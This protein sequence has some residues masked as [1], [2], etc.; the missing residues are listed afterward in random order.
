VKNKP[1]SRAKA[2]RLMKSPRALESACVPELACVAGARSG[3]SS[4]AAAA[5]YVGSSFFSTD[6]PGLADSPW[7]IAARPQRVLK[8]PRSSDKLKFVGQNRETI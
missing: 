7:A 8:C 2:W 1:A 6:S 5:H 3:Q 4:A